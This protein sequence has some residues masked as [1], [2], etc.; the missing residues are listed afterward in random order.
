MPPLGSTRTEAGCQEARA[1]IR[2]DA[3]IGL[4]TLSG[5]PHGP[6]SPRELF[7][8]RRIAAGKGA[9]EIA[10]EAGLT[11]KTISTCRARILEKLNLANT[12][13]LVAYA[14]EHGL[15]DG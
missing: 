5:S 2:W 15:A 11:V 1:V 6:L 4:H 12:A 10:A 8:L 14:Q 7:V 3:M 13:A 9:V